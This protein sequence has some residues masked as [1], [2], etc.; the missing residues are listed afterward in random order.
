M[1][2]A[3]DHAGDDGVF[4][5]LCDDH[6]NHRGII[7]CLQDQEMC[8]RDRGIDAAPGGVIEKEVEDGRKN[9]AAA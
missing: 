8:I 2:S 4:P 6:R 7:Q 3:D 1:Q 5:D 9:I